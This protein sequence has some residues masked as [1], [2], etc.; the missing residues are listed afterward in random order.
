MDAQARHHEHHGREITVNGQPIRLSDR[1]STGAQIL[2]EAGFEPVDEHVLIQRMK[3]GS[4]LVS[5]DEV[6]NLHEGVG[7]FY[8]FRTGEVFTFTVNTHGFQ[9][10]RP[11]ITEPEL[12]EFVDVGD[13][14]V[15][16]QERGDDEPRILGADDRVE[17]SV[18]GAE[19]LR[20]EKRLATVFLDN[21][22]K[23]IPRGV[24][25]TEQLLVL[26]EVPPGYLLNLATEDGLTPLKP[27]QRVRVKDGMRFFSQVPAGGSAR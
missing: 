20:T 6:V 17:L 3:I 1:Q 5:L 21:V 11:A 9:W 15:L 27:E 14:E 23:H 24:H 16:V 13:D 10:G 8:A 25:T 7:R 2:A 4:Q 19:H 18:G 12:R 26:L 22:E